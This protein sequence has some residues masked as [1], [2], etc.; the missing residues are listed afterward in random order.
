MTKEAH[1]D[2]GSDVDAQ[3]VANAFNQASR[4][5]QQRYDFKRT[6]ATIE[7][8]DNSLTMMANAEVRVNATLHVLQSKLVRRG[9]SLKAL[10]ADEPVAQ[11]KQIKIDTVIK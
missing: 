9:I 11:G 1:F 4:E 8:K 10:E 2:S 5:L 7:L 6:C 3:E